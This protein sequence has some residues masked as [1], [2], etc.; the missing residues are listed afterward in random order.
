MVQNTFSSG[1]PMDYLAHHLG[2]MHPTLETT[3]LDC[4]KGEFHPSEMHSIS[5]PGI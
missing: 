3:G 5:E 1:I 2:C 4:L